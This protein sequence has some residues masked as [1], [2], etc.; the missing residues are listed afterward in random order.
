ME[1]VLAVANELKSLKASTDI[2][3]RR[4]SFV[5]CRNVEIA[6]TVQSYKSQITTIASVSYLKILTEDNPVPP[7]CARNIVNKDLAVYLQ[8]RGAV[9]REAEHEK[10]RKKRKDVQKQYDTLSQ[11]MSASGYRKKAPQSKQDDDMKKLATLLEE[12]EIISEAEST[13]DAHS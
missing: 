6:A 13:L 2:H 8:L 7:D 12:L 11:K 1:I 9:N 5:L 3:E 10:L 4:P